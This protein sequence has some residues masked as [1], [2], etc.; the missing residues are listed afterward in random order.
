MT[1][2]LIT[3]ADAVESLRRKVHQKWADAVC[4]DLGV[5]GSV[6]FSVPLRPGVSTG[7]TIAR[8]GHAAWHEWH[9]SWREFA[10][11]YPMGVL[12]VR[13]P[14][15][16][17]GVTDDYPA[18]LVADL[19][20]AVA[21]VS[22][23]EPLALD[24]TR[25]RELASSLQSTGALLSPATLRAVHQLEDDDAEVLLNAVTWL[26]R[27]PNAGAWTARQ[28]PVP[29]MHTKWL[30][31]HGALLRDVAGRDVRD[32]VRS[33]PAVLH[34]TYVDPDHA[35]SGRRRHDAWTTGDTHDIAYRPRI[36]LVVENR[37]SRLWFPPVPDTIVV[38]GGGK[39][40]AA[41]LANVPWIR[42]ADHI[43][44]WGDIDADGY[45]ILDRFRA[46]L[47]EPAPDNAPPKPVTSILMDA[48][49]LHH[50]AEH[51]VNHDKAGRPIK[52]SSAILPH[53]TEA[54]ATAYATVAT[55]SP[56]PF[57]RI[58]QETIP[59]THAATRLLDVPA[60]SH[61]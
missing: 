39:A 60:S 41:L 46:A 5:G 49:D 57:R 53:L 52:P 48:T 4:A 26:R 61:P 9:M 25:A 28:L 45:A 12:I 3:P 17:Q 58:E 2:R 7:S 22:E 20:A 14:V 23:T 27:H 13:K 8:I 1:P 43:V 51:G 21:L 40:A 11:R 31:T 47:A 30:D 59:L 44:Y 50:Y 15:S 6:T 56:T 29:G 24:V 32:E 33:R 34:L 16:V 54:E 38:E 18:T 19:N 42:A 35:T 37:D 36:V 10:D 55:A